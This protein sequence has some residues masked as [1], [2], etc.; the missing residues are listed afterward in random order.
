MSFQSDE[1]C[2]I[3]PEKENEI[4]RLVESN[5]MDFNQDMVNMIGF[6]KYIT[7]QAEEDVDYN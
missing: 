4:K 6:I 5:S 7:E 1:M 2:Q 3:Y